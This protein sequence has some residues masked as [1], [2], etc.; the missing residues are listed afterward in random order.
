VLALGAIAG[1]LFAWITL[2]RTTP[3]SQ[4]ERDLRLKHEDLV[5][6]RDELYAKLRGLEDPDLNDS[7]RSALERLA[8]VTLKRLAEVEGQRDQYQAKS[9]GETPPSKGGG[10]STFTSRHPLL[11]GFLLGGGMVALVAFLVV[12]ADRNAKPAAEQ[13]PSAMSPRAASTENASAG[14]DGGA[15][16]PPGARELP[17]ELAAEIQALREQLDG[18]ANDLP[19]LEGITE[20]FLAGG[21]MFEAFQ[22]AQAMLEIDPDNSPAHYT[23][24]VVRF[25]MG[26]AEPAFESLDMALANDPSFSQA[27]L[28]KGVFQ[29][30][31]GDREAAVSTWQKG[32]QA[33][34]GSDKR[35][36]HMLSLAEQGLSAEEILQTPPPG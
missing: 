15:G 30:Q 3:E 17:P 5:R 6:Q 31:I 36:E 21:F 8:A 33:A 23:Q 10:S 14:V 18:S 32:L 28:M 29:L 7:D 13:A 24:G 12:S 1:A 34:G 9:R 35:L 11:S 27:A 16:S 19:I 2:P 26:Q 22:E 25:L 4:I 20:T